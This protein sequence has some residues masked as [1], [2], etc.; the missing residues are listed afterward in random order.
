[1]VLT[2]PRSTVTKDGMRAVL[3]INLGLVV[4]MLYCFAL[5][6]VQMWN[7]AVSALI[8]ID[9]ALIDMQ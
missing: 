1:M 4:L 6:I 8:C 2:H 9:I 7:A 5:R 3:P